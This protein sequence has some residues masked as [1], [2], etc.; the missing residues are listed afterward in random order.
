ME[1]NA[2][3][4]GQARHLRTQCCETLKKAGVWGAGGG[5]E[6]SAV[7]CEHAYNPSAERQ[8]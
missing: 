6:G 2:H 4:G 8:R 3:S 7:S 1:Q 5:V